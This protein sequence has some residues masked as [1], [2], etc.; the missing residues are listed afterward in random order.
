ME[1]LIKNSSKRFTDHT[2]I[3]IANHEILDKVQA[4]A[5]C[6][7]DSK[8]YF[9][10]VNEAYTKLYGYSKEELIGQ[11]FTIVLPE[12]FRAYGTNLHDEFIAGKPEMPNEWTV[13]N[14]HGQMIRIMAEA[15][16]C[17]DDKGDVSKVTIIE[18]LD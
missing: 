2:G 15:V 13:Q 4:L 9:I 8:G 1:N 12:E 16:R 6:F 17:E 7:T 18:Q 11:H 5:V 10:E 14:K 3:Q